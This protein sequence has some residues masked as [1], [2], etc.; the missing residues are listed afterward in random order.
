MIAG[1]NAPVRWIR[2]AEALYESPMRNPNVFRLA[3]LVALA[4][5]AC[6]PSSTQLKAVK[7]AHY[8]GDKLA[9]Y[10]AM[11]GAVE[12]KYKLDKSDETT[13]GM[14]TTGR[15]YTPEGLAA[16]ERDTRDL[17][18]RSLNIVL[19]AKLLPDG[20]SWVVQVTPV[21]LRYIA[22]RP[23]PDQLTPDDPSLPGYVGE[24]V[25]AL[26]SNIHDALKQYEVANVPTTAAPP[27]AP[28]AAPGSAAPPPSTGSAAPA[29][30][31][32][33]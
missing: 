3:A 30:A 18:D 19:V 6:G 13:L 9:I 28:G 22:G 5:G 10:N 26:A 7:A 27:A 17:P 12:D 8:R 1:R 11:R 2:G 16:S 21:L 14:Q 15:W 24:K 31:P 20:D 32:A 25:D 29:P 23:N 4:L 33:P